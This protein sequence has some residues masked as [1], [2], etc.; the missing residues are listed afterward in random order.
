VAEA[1]TVAD[2]SRLLYQR[3]QAEGVPAELLVWPGAVHGFLQMTRDVA[4]ARAAM[5]DVARAVRAWI[6]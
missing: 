6:A 1:D 5:A 2:D 3:L 4:L